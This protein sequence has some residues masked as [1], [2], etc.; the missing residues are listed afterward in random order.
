[1]GNASKLN[2]FCMKSEN[3][4][5]GVH[6]VNKIVSFGDDRYGLVYNDN[7]NKQETISGFIFNK[8]EYNKINESV[9]AALSKIKNYSSTIP[10]LII[11]D[12]VSAQQIVF[13]DNTLSSFKTIDLFD[14]LEKEKIK[15]DNNYK[16]NIDEDADDGDDDDDGAD[17]EEEN[18]ENKE[19]DDGD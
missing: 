3:I 4:N 16:E 18:K 7:D 8:G 6:N 12:T 5:D 15:N 13:F 17:K 10:N 19:K 9:K 14:K 2:D 11:S 1:M